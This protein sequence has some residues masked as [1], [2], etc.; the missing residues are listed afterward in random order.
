MATKGKDVGSAGKEKRGTSPSKPL[1]SGSTLTKRC[2]KPSNPDSTDKDLTSASQKQ[3]PSYLRPTISSQNIKKEDS[4]LGPSVHRRRSFD[5]PPSPSQIQKAL[6]S[7]SGRDRAVRS[8]SVTPA[9]PTTA[10]KPISDR[11]S[12]TPRVVKSQPSVI[13]STSTKKTSSN[14]PTKKEASASSA[15]EKKAPTVA[16]T[17]D[18]LNNESEQEDQ[19]SLVH[20]VQ[21]VE[22]KDIDNGVEIPSDSSHFD[23]ENSTEPDGDQDEKLKPC[24][25]STVPENQDSSTAA[26]PEESTEDKIDDQE[27]KDEINSSQPEENSAGEPKVEAQDKQGEEDATENPITKEGD[28]PSTEDSGDDQNKNKVEEQEGDEG[29]QKHA[30]EGKQEHVNEE[31]QKHVVEEQKPEAEN[32]AS[33]RQSANGKKDSQV[34]NEV[35]EETA[36]KLL[37]KRKNKVRALV[38][39]FETVISLQE[40]EAEH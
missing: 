14:P 34:Y 5:K 26:G 1:Q 7:P 28:A 22:V 21:E 36:S 29:S 17:G 38:G 6:L 20:V 39:A 11:T 3:I 9:K 10:P 33:K 19:E 25:T 18:K 4:T 23:V 13:K 16:D 32:V 35:I 27:S 31:R 12:K 24:E 40:P 30:D 2:P 15:S 8:S 37:E